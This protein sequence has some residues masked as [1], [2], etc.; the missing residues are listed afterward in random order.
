MNMPRAQQQLHPRRNDRPAART[1]LFAR[2][3][4]PLAVLLLAA[5]AATATAQQ[6]GAAAAPPADG[7]S[8]LKPGAPVTLNFVNTEIEAVSRAIGAMLN[9]QLIVDPRVKGTI[10]ITTERAVPPQEAYRTFLA[11]LRGMGFTVV[12]NAGLLK[13]VP[14]SDAKLQ[15]GIVNVGPVQARG[16]QVITQ[17]FKLNHENPNNLVAVLRPLIGANNTINAAPSTNSLVITDYADNLAR[18][19]RIIVALDQPAASE[20]EVFPL[21]HAVAAD[22]A[23]LVQR[24]SDAGGGA[25]VPG[26]PAQSSNAAS[27]LVD[28]RSNALIVRT[29]NAARMA[30][31]RAAIEKLDRPTPGGGPA[32][33]IWVVYLK[34]A[35]ATKIA[36][37]LRAAIGGSGGAG[38]SSS[39]SGSFTGASSSALSGNA[40]SAQPQNQPGGTTSGTGTG[41]S[42][43]AATPVAQSARPSTGG[44]I[45]ADPSTNSL[46]IT[47]PEPLYRQIR[48]VIDRLDTRRAQIFIE[49]MIVEIDADK[50]AQFG[51]QWQNLF[52]RKGDDT[53]YGVG[54]NFGS[55]SNNI[56]TLSGALTEGSSG[57]AALAGSSAVAS[58]LNFAIAKNLGPY[59]TIGALA[60]FLQ[61]NTDANVLSTPNLIAL[62]NEEAKIVV[63]QN[64]PF[65]TGSFTSTGT[66]T[67]NPFQTIE[68]QDVGLTL[69]VKPQVGEGNAVRMVIYQENSS[70]VA[71]AAGTSTS[72]PT[73]NKS[74]IETSVTVD[75]GNIMV[76]GG[77]LRDEYQNPINKVPILGDIPLVGNLFRNESRT[78]TKKNLMIFLRPV[79]LRDQLSAD[80][81]TIDRYEA[82]RSLQQA[83]QPANSIILP[84]NEAP[85]LPALPAPSAPQPGGSAPASSPSLSLPQAPA[86]PLTAPAASVPLTAPPA[87]PA[88]T[89]PATPQ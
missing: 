71:Q 27:V 45:Q 59:Y 48:A 88:S 37:V 61:T 24:L 30:T 68:R 77:L 87:P 65:I 32:G 23:P 29:A 17:V 10:T 7:S 67:T 70:V 54:T 49:S 57:V 56:L 20:F 81:L 47:A 9:R 40:L 19:G 15:T 34:N 84:V 78:R 41:A 85:M 16:D 42:G 55:G 28:P 33:S 80:Q 52:G 12:E 36:E 2:S 3:R 18:L 22:V 1:L 53:V 14:E 39:G 31:V 76:L 38:G 21:Q 8:S 73:T 11:A 82:I 72:G 26:V 13:V 44:Q 4:I 62:D 58:G 25:A 6:G 64:V 66:G 46:I 50:V 43:A 86:A 63:G 89:P 51:F 69:R 79:V 75:D 35:D 5:L 83:A 60:N 74:S